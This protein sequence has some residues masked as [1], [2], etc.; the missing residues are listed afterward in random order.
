MGYL[1][2]DS[3]VNVCASVQEF[4]ETNLWKHVSRVGCET[5]DACD[6]MH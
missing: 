2:V 5:T 3:H 6:C 1:M 4:L